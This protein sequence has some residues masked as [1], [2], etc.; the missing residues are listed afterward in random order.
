MKRKISL[1]LSTMTMLAVLVIAAQA[2]KV[3]V[4]QSGP[5]CGTDPVTLNAY[6]ETGFDLPFRLSEEFARQYPNVTW[7]IKQDQFTNL[8]NATPRL[9]S[10]DNPPD[11]IRLP[12][13][14]CF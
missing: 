14:G 4:A 9:L 8:I 7:D 12:T 2:P 10:G 11:L 6:F 1:V 13:R 3:V 5:T